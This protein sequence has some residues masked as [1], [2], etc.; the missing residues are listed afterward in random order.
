M[1]E[2]NA[3][4]WF[5]GQM[6]SISESMMRM[7]PRMS[8]AECARS[9]MKRM[10]Y[11]GLASHVCENIVLTDDCQRLMREAVEAVAAGA[12]NEYLHPYIY[13]IVNYLHGETRELS[14][15]NVT[16][17]S[18]LKKYPHSAARNGVHVG[19]HASPF[20]KSTMRACCESL[21]ASC[22]A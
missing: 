15:P 5:I 2:Q 14:L 20:S 13:A 8:A 16:H 17:D 10:M 1:S 19:Q 18:F 3:K 7:V 21:C 11:D 6:D 9:H 22:S 12:E 4:A